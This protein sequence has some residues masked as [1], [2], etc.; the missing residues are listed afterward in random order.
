MGNVL[1]GVNCLHHAAK[2]PRCLSHLSVII[3]RTSQF[4]PL[5]HHVSTIFQCCPDPS[6]ELNITSYVKWYWKMKA[7]LSCGVDVSSLP[8]S[9]IVIDASGFFPCCLCVS[10]CIAP[11]PFSLSLTNKSVGT[12]KLLVCSLTHSVHPV[13][14]S[15]FLFLLLFLSLTLL[16]SCEL[17]PLHRTG[18]K[19]TR[20]RP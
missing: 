13:S 1:E 15:G 14:V 6:I 12:K 10:C 16:G 8:A 7:G 11:N 9:T 5:A 20:R 17:L 18:L 4:S 19:H 3:Q 2:S